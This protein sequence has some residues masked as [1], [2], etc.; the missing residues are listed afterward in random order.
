M[1]MISIQRGSDVTFL[2]ILSIVSQYIHISDIGIVVELAT[3]HVGLGKWD[4]SRARCR[5]CGSRPLQQRCLLT[6]RWAARAGR[7]SRAARR[8][9]VSAAAVP[10]P[11]P[12]ATHVPPARHVAPVV[13]ALSDVSSVVFVNKL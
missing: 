4:E 11:E 9:Q 13:C 2:V 12:R 5:A 7:G 1:V 10:R 6:S 8:P 3:P